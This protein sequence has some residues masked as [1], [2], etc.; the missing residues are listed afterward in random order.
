MGACSG[1]VRVQA[2]VGRCAANGAFEALI[3]RAS[4]TAHREA[5]TDICG[6]RHGLLRAGEPAV[7]PAQAV[8]DGEGAAGA[9]NGGE[10]SAEGGESKG[11]GGTWRPWV[12]ADLATVDNVMLVKTACFF[13]IG[14][15][16][17]TL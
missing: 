9:I 7:G 16:H 11:R 4:S 5:G 8:P 12:A 3:T 13:Q 10:G 2:L 15:R 14:P 17:C 6:G 1:Q